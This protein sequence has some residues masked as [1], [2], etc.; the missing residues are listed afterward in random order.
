VRRFLF[1][2]GHAGNVA[3]IADVVEQMKQTYQGTRYAQV[4][5]WRFLIPHAASVSESPLPHGHASEHG[6]SVLLVVAP[7]LVH[8]DRA[9]DNPAKDGVFPEI[10]QYVSYRKRA[11]DGVLGHATVGTAG[12]GTVIAQRAVDRIV[13]FVNSPAFTL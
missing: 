9:V 13:E 2:N 5:V 1:V 10:I 3:I 8:M 7:H 12:K 11:P 4:D 6:T